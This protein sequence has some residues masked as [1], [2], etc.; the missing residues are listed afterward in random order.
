MVP[1]TTRE[2][3]QVS[4]HNSRKTR[5][6]SPQEEMRLFSAVASREKSHLP[7]CV[8]NGSLTPFM[9]HI[10]IPNI[11]ISI[12]EEPQGS[13]H[14]SRRAPFFPPHLEMR[15]HFPALS[16]KES[17]HFRCTSRGGCLNLK[18][19]RYSRG[20][21]TIPTDPMSQSTPDTPD[22]SALTR[23]SPRVST[24]NTVASVTACRK[25]A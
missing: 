7:F 2:E 9:Q 20:R 16:G 22:S 17:R 23:L 5:R 19:E 13:C 11:T 24:H 4:C 25:P 18:L 21:A 6:F 12:G 14:N 15:V 10:K 3:P 1:S 8:S